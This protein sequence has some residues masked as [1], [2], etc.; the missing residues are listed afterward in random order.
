MLGISR[1]TSADLTKRES[2]QPLIAFYPP[3][4]DLDLIRWLVGLLDPDNYTC[5]SSASASVGNL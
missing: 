5:G 2:K 1:L 4:P 3:G